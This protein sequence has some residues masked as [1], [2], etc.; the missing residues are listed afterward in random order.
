MHDS[1]NSYQFSIGIIIAVLIVTFVLVTGALASP[2]A[3]ETTPTPPAG[4]ET[5]PTAVSNLSISDDVCLECHGQPG[6]TMQLENGDLL[7]LYVPAEAHQNSVHGELGYACVQCHAD[8]G[9]YPHPEFTAADQRDATLQLNVT[10]Q[11]CHQ[12]EFDLT[13]DSVHAAALEQGNRDAAVC[14]DC[15]TA[16]DVRRLV[17]P[18]TGELLP[19]A[20]AWI[21]Q[22]CARC[23][24]E[25]YNKYLD[26]VHGSALLDQ[27]NPEV[28]TCID[29]HG[30]HNIEDPT[31]SAFRLNSPQ[32]CAE[33]HTDPRIMDKYGISTHVLDTYVADFHGTSVVLFEPESPD[34]EINKPVCFDCH[35]VHDIA[36]ADDPHKGLQVRQNLL[37]RC[38]ACH[39]D[40]T[41]NFPDSWMSHYIPSLEK[42]PLVFYV[43]LFYL[44]II[45][46]V[47]GGMA[48][49]VVMDASRA[50]LNR[51]RA[52]KEAEPVETGVET[53]R[54]GAE[55]GAGD[56]GPNQDNEE[57]GD[58]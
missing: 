5:E 42:N 1:R 4:Q 52:R 51:Y 38:Q 25:I 37:V 22:T 45:P 33:C 12:S 15:H 31:T 41:E 23:H 2:A 39:P 36:S 34:A 30:V 18:E 21:P 20:R 8:V 24:S 6:A 28:P 14:S 29:C 35:G 57:A 55:S 11:R 17:D 27:G 43:N 16:H 48:L 44:I 58:G 3:Q 53:A 50:G 46:V 9:E 19:D 54:E 13:M 49:L 47:V 40:A 26:S 32:M 56:M 7:D 10:C